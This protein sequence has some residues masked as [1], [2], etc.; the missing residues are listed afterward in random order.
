MKLRLRREDGVAVMAVE[1]SLSQENVPLFRTRLDRLLEEGEANIV[2]DMT[3]SG[4]I[5][6]MGLAVLVRAKTRAAAL[7][8]DVK[9]T[10]S[11][12]LITNLLRITNLWRKFDMYPSVAEALRSFGTEV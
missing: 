5:S 10:G 11:G 1:G 12:Q 8:G 3:A 4:Y 7:S 9:I 2:V 6:S